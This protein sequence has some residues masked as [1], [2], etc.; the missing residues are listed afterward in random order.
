MA[1]YYELRNHGHG[2]AFV[3]DGI[4]PKDAAYYIE[5]SGNALTISQKVI[6]PPPGLEL[7]RP[8]TPLAA[9]LDPG[10]RLRHKLEIR[11][12]LHESTPY[13]HLQPKRERGASYLVLE[14]HFE[15][16]Y[17]VAPDP[18]VA[19]KAGEGWILPG[20]EPGMQSILRAGPIGRISFDPARR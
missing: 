12:P 19:R 18:A 6:A 9:R 10:Q 1:L 13:P 5:R 2:T 3:F 15:A 16:G 4:A 8:E 14:A 11:L 20:L 7:E 17:F